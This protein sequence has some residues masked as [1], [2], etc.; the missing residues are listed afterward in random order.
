MPPG[1]HHG[2]SVEEVLNGVAG[3]AR[4]DLVPDGRP[5]DPLRIIARSGRNSPV[6]ADGFPRNNWTAWLATGG[7]LR[8]DG[9]LMRPGNRS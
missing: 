2:H 7:R 3:P 9:H 4:R 8:R 5:S 1:S 6:Q